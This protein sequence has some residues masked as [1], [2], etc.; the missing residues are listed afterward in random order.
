MDLFHDTEVA[1]HATW[2]SDRRLLE[3]SGFGVDVLRERV[4]VVEALVSRAHETTLLQWVR[5][6][7]KLFGLARH[8][9][10]C[11]KDRRPVAG[12]VTR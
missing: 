10:D 9:D 7:H 1:L 12:G 2:Q 5:D 3:A 8:P 6:E 4:S 11:E